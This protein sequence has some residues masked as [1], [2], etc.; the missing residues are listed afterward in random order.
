MGCKKGEKEGWKEGSRKEGMKQ[1]SKKI[2]EDGRME[3]RKHE[4][5]EGRFE[6]EKE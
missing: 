4:V 2:R 1:G 5:K 3:Y 6:E